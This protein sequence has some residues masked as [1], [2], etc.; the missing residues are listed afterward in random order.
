MFETLIGYYMW[1]TA[2]KK[3][4]EVGTRIADGAKKVYEDPKKAL[5]DVYETAKD[6]VI[7]PLAPRAPIVMSEEGYAAKERLSARV[8]RTT[9]LKDMRLMPQDITKMLR[10]Y[11]LKKGFFRRWFWD[12]AGVNDLRYFHD[13]MMRS[14]TDEEGYVNLSTMMVNGHP[15][16]TVDGYAYALKRAIKSHFR[17]FSLTAEIYQKLIDAKLSYDD[18][19]INN[20]EQTITSTITEKLKPATARAMK[21][22]EVKAKFTLKEKY[23]R[24]KKEEMEEPICCCYPKTKR[25]MR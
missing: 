9:V 17:S 23:V 24:E 21:K 18:F 8:G 12:S 3:V 11:D 25:K 7:D 5:Y 10:D 16:N 4:T 15:F 13:H 6:C 22:K 14:Y 20:Q 2:T 1:Q 19:Q